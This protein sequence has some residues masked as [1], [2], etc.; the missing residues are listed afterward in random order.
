MNPWTNALPMVAFNFRVTTKVNVGVYPNA[1][2]IN[3][4]DENGEFIFLRGMMGKEKQNK[5]NVADAVLTLIESGIISLEQLHAELSYIMEVME[6]SKK[7]KTQNC[8]KVDSSHKETEKESHY[9][10]YCT[11]EE[12][13]DDAEKT[14]QMKEDDKEKI[15]D[16]ESSSKATDKHTEWK[17]NVEFLTGECGVEKFENE[18]ELKYFEKEV[19]TFG[20]RKAEKEIYDDCKIE[21]FEKLQA[22]KPLNDRQSWNVGG[23]YPGKITVST[24]DI[25]FLSIYLCF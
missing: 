6:H 21:K 13:Y 4:Y 23:V 18:E 24:M 2:I 12:I 11:K 5:T 17:E 19:K 8:K 7:L 15:S 1:A 3:I 16:K 20:A 14:D 9:K 25:L 10:V 22:R